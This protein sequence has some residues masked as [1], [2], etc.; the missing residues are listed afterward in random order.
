MLV[1]YIYIMYN[2]LTEVF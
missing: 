2:N 1:K